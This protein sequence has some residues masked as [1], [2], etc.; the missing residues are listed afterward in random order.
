MA[1]DI[2]ACLHNRSR[3]TYGDM[4]ELLNP[5]Q[6]IYPI[7]NTQFQNI[8]LRTYNEDFRLNVNQ[9][10]ATKV[11]LDIYCRSH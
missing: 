11:E 5:Q 2:V 8:R 6:D 3:D 4:C 10:L 1:T 7:T 9:H